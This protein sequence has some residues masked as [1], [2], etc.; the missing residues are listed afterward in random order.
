MSEGSVF[1]FT[2]HTDAITEYAVPIV[3]FKNGEYFTPGT[4][5]MIGP[6]FA[7]TAKHVFEDLLLRFDNRRLSFDDP[8]MQ[9][10]V[11]FNL[12]AWQLIDR[13]RRLAI[14]DVRKVYP[15]GV[16]DVAF[17]ELNAAN[18]EA[19]DY[20]WR[21]AVKLDLRPPKIGATVQSFGYHSGRFHIAPDGDRRSVLLENSPATSLGRVVAVHMPKRDS[22]RLTFPCFQ[23]DARFD[24]GMSGGPVFLDGHLCGLVCSN[25]PPSEVGQSH[26]SYVSLL[27]PAM[28]TMIDLPI[29]LPALGSRYSVLDL[30]RHGLLEA[31]GWEQVIMERDQTGRL[32]HLSWFEPATSL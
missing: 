23:T 32:S 8:L 31:V 13:G 18:V 27:W 12:Q 17:M 16:T 20:H 19:Q 10:D 2:P 11:T 28:S 21:G 24:G 26:V 15:S 1:D 7:V 22:A 3:G 6:Y 29:P 5:F 14:W 9:L 25:L 30:A 4:A